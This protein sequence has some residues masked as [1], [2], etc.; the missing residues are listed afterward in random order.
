MAIYRSDQAQFTFAAGEGPPEAQLATPLPSGSTLTTTLTEATNPGDTVLTLASAGSLKGSHVSGSDLDQRF[1]IIDSTATTANQVTSGAVTH[2]SVPEVRR[3]THVSGTSVTVDPPVAFPHGI[4]AVVRNMDYSAGLTAQSQAESSNYGGPDIDRYITWFPG[5]YDSVDCPDVEESFDQRY[6]L[7][8]NTN[9]NV[10]Q[11]YKGQQAYSGSVSGMVLLN[12]F[13]LRFPLG[14]VIS[15]PA[16]APSAISN[17][18]GIVGTAGSP[19]V[20]V[21]ATGGTGTVAIANGATLCLGGNGAAGSTQ[22]TGSAT[23]T[24]DAR[25]E[26]R[27]V[28]SGGGTLAHDAFIRLNYPLFFDHESGSNS[29][30]TTSIAASGA[31]F[32]HH[33]MEDVKLPSLAWNVNVKDDEGANAFQRRYYGGKIDG[34]TLS[35]DAGGLITCDWNASSFLGMN[36]NIALSD[37][38]GSNTGQLTSSE[39]VRGFTFMHDIAKTD[40]GSPALSG[41]SNVDGRYLPTTEPYY[42]SEGEIKFFGTTVG[43]IQNFSLDISNALEPKY[44][45]EQR[46]NDNRGPKEIFEGQR[47][48]SMTATVGLPDSADFVSATQHSLFKEIMQASDHPTSSNY[49]NLE[50]VTIS[51][52]FQRAN[53]SADQISIQIPSDGAEGEG[54]LNQGA[55][56]TAAPINVD[57]AN[58]MEQSV[59]FMVPNLKIKISDSEYFYP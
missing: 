26:I 29:G 6:V 42:F 32:V 37:S 15:V 25:Q 52:I 9:R 49:T 22:L 17:C 31:T 44:Y 59:N 10:Y 4:G 24:A 54:G 27:R 16:A 39:N 47:T 2:Y 12:G 57:G 38:S 58:P 40:I 11:Y 46:G 36:H 13:P 19:M 45:V 30:T 23:P 14:K 55:I 41:S 56:L 43:R 8:Q 50:G 1:I 18:A 28:V 33:L 20:Q 21:K 48:Y 34:L 7:G 53:N 51:L 35:A 3:V 5:V